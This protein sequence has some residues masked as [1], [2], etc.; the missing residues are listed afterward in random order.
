M[1][2]LLMAQQSPAWLNFLQRWKC[3]L[4]SLSSMVGCAEHEVR[5]GQLKS[6]IFHFS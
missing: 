3:S 1:G 6:R 4:S 2:K 5:L